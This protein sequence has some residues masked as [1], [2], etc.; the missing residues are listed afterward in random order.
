MKGWGKSGL[1]KNFPRNTR[2]LRDR[3]KQREAQEQRDRQQGQQAWEDMKRRQAWKN[4][5]K[6][7]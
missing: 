5:R 2:E 3:Q 7:R 1:G 4:D 6:G